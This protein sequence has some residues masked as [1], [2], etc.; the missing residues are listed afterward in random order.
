MVHA[1]KVPLAAEFVPRAL[2]LFSHGA[3]LLHLGSHGLE[4]I[5]QLLCARGWRQ[6][7]RPG[8]RDREREDRT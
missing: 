5:L 8:A 7:A 2:R 4:A 1:V 6:R 3:H